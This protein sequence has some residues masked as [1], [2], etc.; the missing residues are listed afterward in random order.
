MP[1]ARGPLLDDAEKRR[2]AEL[3]QFNGEVPDI[4]KDV[5]QK[6]SSRSRACEDALPT[7]S[8]FAPALLFYPQSVKFF[9]KLNYYFFGYF[10]PINIFFDNK[11]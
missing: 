4:S 2:F 11:K 7:Q 6:A 1:Q 10:D 9:S 3:M 8:R 5:L